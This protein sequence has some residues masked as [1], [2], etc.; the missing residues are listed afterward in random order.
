MIYPGM[1]AHYERQKMYVFAICWYNKLN[2]RIV[3]I[4][5][6]FIYE[7]NRALFSRYY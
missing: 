2:V 6:R 5:S 4:E 1:S 7:F 3:E